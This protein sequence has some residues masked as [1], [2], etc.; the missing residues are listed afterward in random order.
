MNNCQSCGAELTGANLHPLCSA[1][2]NSLWLGKEEAVQIAGKL[3]ARIAELEQRID[4][5]SETMWAVVG[6]RDKAIAEYAEILAEKN[7]EIVSLGEQL[8]QVRTM[9]AAQTA[10][11]GVLKEGKK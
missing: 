9:T 6:I 1:C 8:A 4:A 2:S 7:A 3:L 5:R 11:I 10:A